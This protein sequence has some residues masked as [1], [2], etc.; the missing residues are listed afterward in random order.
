VIFFKKAIKL[1]HEV[2][3]WCHH[4]SYSNSVQVFV[5]IQ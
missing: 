4:P 3:Q 1:N 5:L 2:K